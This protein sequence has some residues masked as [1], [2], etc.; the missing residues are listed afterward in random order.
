MP[1]GTITVPAKAR[2]KVIEGSPTA[3]EAELQTFLQSLDANTQLH[4]F[5]A[6]RSKNDQ[7][8][9]IVLGYEIP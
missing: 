5:T 1:F 7:E 8:I 6:T 4:S 2:A 9:T 3:V